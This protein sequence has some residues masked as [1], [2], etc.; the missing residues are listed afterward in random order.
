MRDYLEKMLD[1]MEVEEKMVEIQ[2]KAFEYLDHTDLSCFQNCIWQM[3][4][5]FIFCNHIIGE[6]MS[7]SFISKKP[8]RGK[9]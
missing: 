1:Q 4:Y 2:S 8:D 7:T 5:Y 6:K 3:K 9:L